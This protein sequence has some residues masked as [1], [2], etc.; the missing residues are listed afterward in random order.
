M[1]AYK[2]EEFKIHLRKRFLSK[3]ISRKT[4]KDLNKNNNLNLVY[5]GPNDEKF[6]L[7]NLKLSNI[8]PDNNFIKIFLYHFIKIFIY[9]VL[10]NS[11][12]IQFL[13]K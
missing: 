6:L 9:F 10:K 5:K 3:F 12:L 2:L 8:F 13:I 4:I 1:Y 7:V 11:L